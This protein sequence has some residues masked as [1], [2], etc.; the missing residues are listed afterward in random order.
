MHRGNVW[1]AEYIKHDTELLPGMSLHN[2]LSI[3]G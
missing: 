3:R 1:L 2:T